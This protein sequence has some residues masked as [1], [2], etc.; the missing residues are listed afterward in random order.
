MEVHGPEQDG[1]GADV[2]VVV[3]EVLRQHGEVAGAVRVRVDRGSRVPGV[4]HEGLG[5]GQAAEHGGVVGERAGEE[6]APRGGHE[7]QGDDGQVRGAAE[8]EGE[9][10]DAA[11]GHHVPAAV[12]RRPVLLVH[13]AQAAERVV[14]A[15]VQEAEREHRRRRERLPGR[16]PLVVRGGRLVE[17][18]RHAHEDGGHDE[19]ERDGH[20]QQGEIP[21]VD[22]EG[23]AGAVAVA[24]F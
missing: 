13:G 5:E 12:R 19:G 20:G 8:R 15:V 16:D 6:L 21:E 17:E 2:E 18:A 14:A 23:A 11:H 9:L 24:V 1:D 4:R 3:Q 10:V 7:G 22:E